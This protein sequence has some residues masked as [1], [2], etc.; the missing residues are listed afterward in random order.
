MLSYEIG[1]DVVDVGLHRG[2]VKIMDEIW[3]AIFGIVKNHF[4]VCL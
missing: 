4:A 1:I 2:R 3:I